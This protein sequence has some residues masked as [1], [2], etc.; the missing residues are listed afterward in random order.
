MLKPVQ[1]WV[2]GHGSAS[3]FC[4]EVIR[5]AD[6]ARR[7]LQ[8][9]LSAGGRGLLQEWIPGRREAI[10]LFFAEGRFWARFAQMSH[11]EWPVSGGVSVLC[12]G[13]TPPVDCMSAAEEL[14]R[15]IGLEGC[16][17]VE[18]RRDAAN[19][20]V[21][22]EINPRMGSSVELA[23]LRLGVNLPQLLLDWKLGEPLTEMT[24]YRQGRRLRWL[25]GDIW[26]L[27]CTLD[28]EG[29]PDA[30]P[31]SASLLRF[32]FDSIRPGNTLDV[33]D[34]GDMR[35]ALSEMNEMVLRHVWRRV[36]RCVPSLPLSSVREVS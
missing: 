11:R 30:R 5:T 29:E 7:R 36:R 15:Q 31:R 24:S 22:M 9:L 14:V 16:S 20:P 3:R 17:M 33:F 35:P 34:W 1:S 23:K 19:R 18:F 2:E 4:C 10:S 21:L 6:E 25:A 28:S 27:K 26:N 32:V 8:P 12:E 13:I